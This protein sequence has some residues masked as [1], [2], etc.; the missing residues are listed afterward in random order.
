MPHRRAG[1]A[2]ESLAL[3]NA[4]ATGGAFAVALGAIVGLFS[5]NVALAAVS[6]SIGAGGL[7]GWLLAGSPTLNKG[8]KP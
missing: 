7:V 3:G 1:T 6:L 5:Q 2:G 4:V 8:S